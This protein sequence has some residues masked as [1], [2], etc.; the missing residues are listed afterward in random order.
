MN[1]LPPNYEE[2]ADDEIDEH[3]QCR[4]YETPFAVTPGLKALLDERKAQHRS[5][6]DDVI[7]N[8]VVM[9]ELKAVISELRFKAAEHDAS[10][11]AA[12]QKALDDP[13]PPVPHAEVNAHFAKLRSDALSPRPANK[14]LN[15]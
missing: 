9:A 11:R 13:R 4:V 14:K 3:W 5:N 1:P 2:M 7:P 6:P 15:F 10:F 8:E 12:I